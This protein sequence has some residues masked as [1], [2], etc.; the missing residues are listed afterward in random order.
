MLRASASKNKLNIWQSA[1]L[2]ALLGAVV[3]LLAFF[4]PTGVDWEYT[5]SQLTLRHPYQVS[6]YLNP[7]FAV[8]FLPHRLL[9]M[10]WGNAVN[11][12]LNVGV[13]LLAVHQLE[14]GWLALAL[15][16]SSPVFFDL[17]RTNNIDWLPLLGL[18]AGERWGILLLVSKPQSLGAAAL[19]WAR[20]DWR[21][22]LV[23]AVAFAA[24][25]L[26]WGYWP[27]R[28]QFDPVHT[29]F[30]F[31]PFPVGV[32]YGVYLLWRAW[33]S[34]DPYLAA[35][36]TPLLMPYIAPYSIT[37]V[38]VVLSS[39]YRTAALWFYLVIWAFVVIEVRRL[40]G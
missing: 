31:A 13:L 33:R 19:I 39:R 27:G 20:R 23:P 16:F 7:P 2:L 40:N 22:L 35:V 6:S 1:A 10:A 5:F 36:S 29:V 15:V 9:P 30:N 17:A 21:V 32:P 38:L 12:A 8:A 34:D 11:M 4:Y 26:L 18:L 24:S 3:T 28:V 37:G 25:F 14:G